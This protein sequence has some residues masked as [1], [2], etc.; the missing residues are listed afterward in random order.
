[1]FGT[2]VCGSCGTRYIASASTLK[3][4]DEGLRLGSRVQCFTRLVLYAEARRWSG[5]V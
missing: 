4:V 1:V 5:S 2:S 3:E